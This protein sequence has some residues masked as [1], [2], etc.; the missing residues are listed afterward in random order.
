MGWII[1]ARD[2]NDIDNK[3]K[4][5]VQAEKSETRF[6]SDLTAKSLF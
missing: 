6:F 3:I 2:L 4:S 5:K 1:I